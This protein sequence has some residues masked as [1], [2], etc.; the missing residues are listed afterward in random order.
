MSI[1]LMA[2]VTASMHHLL[3]SG[4]AGFALVNGRMSGNQLVEG[5]IRRVLIEPSAWTVRV[6]RMVTIPSQPWL[7]RWPRLA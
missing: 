7:I 4:V 3:P 6:D 5:N 1:K 2:A